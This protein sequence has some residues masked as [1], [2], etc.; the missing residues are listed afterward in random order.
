MIIQHKVHNQ[1]K[2]ITGYGFSNSQQTVRL[3]GYVSSSFAQLETEIYPPSSLQNNSSSSDYTGPAE[4]LFL[5]AATDSQLDLELDFY[6]VVL[7]HK[8]VLI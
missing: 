5:S 3:L 2:K 6:W 4:Q 1:S 7:T 8:A